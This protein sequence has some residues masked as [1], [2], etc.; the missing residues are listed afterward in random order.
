MK[1]ANEILFDADNPYLLDLS[2]YEIHDIKQ[3]SRQVKKNDLFIAIKGHTVDGHKYVSQAIK[4]G[5]HLVLANLNMKEI[6][7]KN[8]SERPNI[9]YVEDT[10]K[11]LSILMNRFLDYPSK[12]MNVFGVTGTNGK[13]TTSNILN[14]I[15]N[16]TNHPSGV[17]GTIGAFA[18]NYSFLT[19]NTTP[20]PLVLQNILSDM[21]TMGIKNTIMEVS[22]IGLVEN[23]INETEISVAIFTNLTHD[24]LDFHGSMENYMHAKGKLFR[25]LKTH[26]IR[27][28]ENF[29]VINE[30]DDFA[31]YFKEQT[32]ASIVTYGINR[33]SDYQAVNINYSNSGTSFTLVHEGASYYVETPL[34]GENNVYNI[35]AAATSAHA[36]F[37]PLE[38]I[39]FA[40]KS[41]ESVS[42][43]LEVV[44][45]PETDDITVVVDYAHTP[46]GL[47][48]T[49]KILQLLGHKNII[50]VFG[51][52]GDRDIN[53]R[54]LMAQI[55][56]DYSNLAIF[57][58]GHP[59]TE[60]QNIIF[61][62][63]KNGLRG[64]NYLQITDRSEAIMYA[65][66]N[67]QKDDLVLIA[68]KGH[69]DY[70]IIGREK[71]PFDD[72]K[73]A[74]KALQKRKKINSL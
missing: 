42:G 15:L 3:D 68:G 49:L 4:N 65:I 17:I 43:R 50:S 13:T 71:Y 52:N 11:Y 70:Q 67:A 32:K 35:L 30:D 16:K 57:T 41:V 53:K 60:D 24:H 28:E 12:K 72:H 66:Q 9:L 33:K 63:M 48:K 14:H 44:T 73:V 1:N 59:R 31:Y 34:I 29:A 10:Y 38:D 26:N 19:E 69:E 64:E 46:I 2:N 54:P 61:E 23:R 7:E 47:E 39:I 22:S 21:A 45:D 27:G 25:E 8:N 40:L 5:A 36:K 6:L 20:D 62:D 56:V 55:G 37:V 51:C 74:E 58:T 18:N